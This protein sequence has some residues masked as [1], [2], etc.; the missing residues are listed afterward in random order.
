[1]NRVSRKIR[2]W[3]R[4][5]LGITDEDDGISYGKPC[6]PDPN[7]DPTQTLTNKTLSNPNL[8]Y[9]K[10]TTVDINKPLPKWFVVKYLSD[11]HLYNS[12]PTVRNKMHCKLPLHGL[13]NY[14]E[15]VKLYESAI[16]AEY[17]YEF[18]EDY[19]KYLNSLNENVS[20]FII[21]K[22]AQK[23]INENEIQNLKS[24]DS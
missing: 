13:I 3:V 17:F 24:I 1:M 6:K 2:D 21:S 4:N 10:I 7:A 22:N 19:I 15:S 5:W 12:A 8:S 20:K 23:F 9:P 18:G 11:H 16:G 14:L